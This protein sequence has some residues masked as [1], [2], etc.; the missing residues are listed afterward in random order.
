[1]EGLALDVVGDVVVV[2]EAG[3]VM[4]RAARGQGEH[5]V[6]DSDDHA[7]RLID[8]LGHKYARHEK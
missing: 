7:Q 5:D 8:A 4:T 3:E 2:L 6:D 1:M